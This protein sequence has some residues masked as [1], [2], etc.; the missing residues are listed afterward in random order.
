[1]TTKTSKSPSKKSTQT[2]RS[3]RPKGAKPKT[4]SS[5]EKTTRRQFTQ[6]KQWLHGSRPRKPTPLTWTDDAKLDHYEGRDGDDIWVVLTPHVDL[7]P[8]PKRLV[9]EANL[10]VRR[11]SA[12]TQ[13]T[14]LLTV[15]PPPKDSGLQIFDAR[16]H[17]LAHISNGGSVLYQVTAKDVPDAKKQLAEVVVKLRLQAIDGLVHRLAGQLKRPPEAVFHRALRDLAKQID[18]DAYAQEYL[19]CPDSCRVR[20]SS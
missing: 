15:K 5:D 13:R 9:K 1:M 17:G 6:V 8:A 4:Q 20:M 16:I 12:D 18:H 11:E 19:T 14:S 10:K 7:G 3:P 2:K